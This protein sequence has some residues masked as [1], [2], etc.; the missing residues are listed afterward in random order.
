MA[1]NQVAL[2][3]KE[4][5]SPEFSARLAHLEQGQKIGAIVV[6]NG[7]SQ[8]EKKVTR[9]VS[10]ATRQSAVRKRRNAATQALPQID[11]ILQRFGGRRLA[12]SPNALGII[13]VETTPAG[14][15]ALAASKHVKAVLE[16]QRISLM[17]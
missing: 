6:V 10:R 2:S 7:S 5:I 16:N 4:K 1:M 17:R 9:R 13:P 8:N 11:S 3:Q 12:N 14:I 15:K